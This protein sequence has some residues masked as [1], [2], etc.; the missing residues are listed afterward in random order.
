MI[1]LVCS[2]VAALALAG[3]AQLPPLEDRP[4]STYLADTQATTLGR[5]VRATD[6]GDGRSGM[7]TLSDPLEAFAARVVLMR[8][9]ERSLDVQYYIWQPD[10]TGLLLLAELR[11]AADRGVRVRLL[12]DDNGVGGLDATL[13]ALDVHPRIE[14]RL[15]NPYPNRRF[16]P[17]GYLTEFERLNRRM[18]NKALVA[19]TQATIVGGRNIG[20][21]YFGADPVLEFADLDVLAAGRIAAEVAQAF[22]EY[23]N[24]DLAYPLA[25][26]VDVPVPQATKALD[27]RLATLAADPATEVYTQAVIRTPLAELV[28][29]RRLTLD[30]VPI[31]L[32]HD[33][34]QKAAGAASPAELLAAQLGEAIGPARESVDLVSPYFVPGAVGTEALAAYSRAGVRMRV[35]TNSLAATDVAAVHAGYAKRRVDLIRAGVRLYETKPDPDLPA[36][37]AS[38]WR[39]VGSSAASLHGKTFAVDRERVF[40]GSF[41]IDPRSLRLNTEMGFVIESPRL[42]AA[43]SDAL[44]RKLPQIAYEVR[45]GPGEDLEWVEQTDAGP[46]VYQDEPQAGLSRRLLVPILSIL[47]VEP[48]L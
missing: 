41:N 32:V 45:L 27:E 22:D 6:P 1:R 12:L 38:D 33:P 37:S 9:A 28:A 48:L 34:P 46:V 31:R 10:T 47:P 17:L 2:L 36:D 3:C 25:A 13:A 30:W 43:I 26:I 15:F 40:V 21:T 14:V 39:V 7:I 42:A 8:A 44:D 18:H 35:V 11:R 5:V 23:W 19:D 24:S 4:A 16:K 29:A 20:D